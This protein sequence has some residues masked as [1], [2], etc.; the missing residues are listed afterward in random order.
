MNTNCP[1][2][3]SSFPQNWVNFHSSSICFQLYLGFKH[4]IKFRFKK[5][6]RKFHFWNQ[7]KHFWSS[8]ATEGLYNFNLINNNKNFYYDFL[9]RLRFNKVMH[10]VS[11]FDC[12]SSPCNRFYP[13][14]PPPPPPLSNS[15]QNFSK[16]VIILLGHFYKLKNK[17]FL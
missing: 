14:T 5:S 9:S 8:C 10:T 12:G 13:P 1:R 3:Y 7:R 16:S 17:I 4:P 2:G 15:V 6:K 11:I